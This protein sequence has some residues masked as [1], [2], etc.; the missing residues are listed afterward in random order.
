MHFPFAELYQDEAEIRCRDG[1]RTARSRFTDPRWR[2]ARSSLISLVSKWPRPRRPRSRRAISRISSARSEP[3][4]RRAA[5]T[6]RS[7]RSPIDSSLARWRPL[8]VLG[9]THRDPGRATD[10]AHSPPRSSLRAALW[11]IRSEPARRAEERR[12]D[13]GRGWLPRAR[14]GRAGRRLGARYRGRDL[15]TPRAPHQGPGHA[16]RTRSRSSRI[17]ARS[18]WATTWST[19]ST[20]SAS[21]SACSTRT[22]VASRSISWSWSMRAA[23]KL[24][25]P[26]YRLNQIQKWAGG[27]GAPKVD[28]LG[29]QTFSKTKQR[30][31][32]QVRQMADELLR[33]YAER[34]AVPGD[35]LPPADDDYRAF[36][37]TFPF[38]E[39]PD[40]A[41]AIAEVFK[42]LE[43][44]RP[45]DRLVCGDV[46]FGKTEV[47]IRAAFRAAQAGKQVA[48]L[49]PDHCARA[50]AHPLVHRTH[51]GLPHQ[52]RLALT[53]PDQ[54]RAS[55]RGARA[56]GRNGG[57]RHRYP[58]SALQRRALASPWPP[59]GRR[60]ATIR[61][62]PQGAHQAAQTQR[63]RSHA[64]RHADSAHA[65]RWR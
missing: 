63:A 32:K 19:S 59:G 50:A 12:R 34:Q 7:I 60:R 24:Y 42:D 37:A 51:A 25:L 28:R 1:A 58:P 64:H 21:T 61:R 65:C 54:A 22:S 4:A 36:E 39:T 40:Q 56:Q 43:L 27:E 44:P 10:L 20:G 52:G 29:G 53:I 35:A 57:H 31:E 48:V 17:C 6:V 16:R 30:I 23:D 18:Q 62:D 9:R 41:R 13:H 5:S 33:L 47:A 2:A 8:G 15:R 38:D 14:C 46:G 11:P 3:R 55:R 45:M 49:C 26:V